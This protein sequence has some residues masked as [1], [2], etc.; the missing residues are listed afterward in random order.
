MP[1]AVGFDHID[2]NYAVKNLT[3]TDE[4]IEQLSASFPAP[5]NKIPMEKY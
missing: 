1:K 2:E 5:V 4:D 3:L